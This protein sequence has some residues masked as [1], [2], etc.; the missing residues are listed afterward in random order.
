MDA[1]HTN[2]ETYTEDELYTMYDE[3]IDD[4]QHREASLVS[5]AGTLYNGYTNRI[6]IGSFSFK[7]SD[8]L[9]TMDPIGYRCGFLDYIADEWEETENGE[10]AR[11][12]EYDRNAYGEFEP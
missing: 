5:P 9:R 7:A 11:S 12:R 4:C 10:Y 2:R 6:H 1:T 3:L 8:I